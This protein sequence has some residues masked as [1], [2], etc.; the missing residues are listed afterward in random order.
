[1][2]N[3]SNGILREVSMD[4]PLYQS[5]KGNYFIGQTPLLTGEDEHALG[6]LLNPIY[7]KKKI[8]VNA[9]TITNISELSL[10]AEFYLRSSFN[11]G[12]TSDLVSCTNTAIFPEPIPKGKIKYLTTTADPI[13]DGVP[14]FTRI[15]PPYSTLVVDGGQ[16]ILGAGQSVV[17]YLGGIISVVPDSAKIAFGWW[18]EKNFDCSN[19]SC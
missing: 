4:Y 17:I 2:T 3:N 13:T 6:A 18:E 14:I 9:M 12:E 7:S 11:N 5:E 19:C 10:S 16:I 1:M 15:V 8:Y